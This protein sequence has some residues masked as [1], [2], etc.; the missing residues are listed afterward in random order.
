MS[1]PTLP[2]SRATVL[3]VPPAVRRLQ[4]SAPIHRV[5]TAAG[6]PAWL[7]TRYQ[8]VRSLLGDDRLGRSHPDPDNAARMNR[9]AL[10]GGQ[11]SGDFDT[12]PA[13]AVRLRRLLQ[14]LFSAK[15]MRRLQTHVD[16]LVSGLLDELATQTPPADLHQAL[17]LPLPVLVICELLGVP[18]ADRADFQAWSNDAGVV[19]D[20]PRSERGVAQLSRYIHELV[21][22]KRVEP[23]EDVLSALCTNEEY[24]LTDAEVSR[25]GAG[26]L[27]AGHETTVTRIGFGTVLLLTNPQQRQALREDPALLATAVEEV[28]RSPVSGSGGLPRYARS[29]IECADVTIQTG[30]LVILDIAAANHDP[31]AFAEPEGFDIARPANTHLGFGHGLHYCIGAPLA[32]I[33]L[34][35]VFSQLFERFPSMRLAV[36]VEELMWQDDQLTGGLASLPVNWD[37]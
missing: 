22:R 25:L 33:E 5:T 11:P 2:F 28:L 6:D 30:D 13:D 18:Y 17:A 7:V 10:F 34:R 24:R 14:P 37:A 19:D 32:R 21:Q 3:E 4:D 9:S 31:R 8:E 23:A 26:L 27:F 1:T 15:H 36:P 20:R 35:A 12:E 16:Q 29:D